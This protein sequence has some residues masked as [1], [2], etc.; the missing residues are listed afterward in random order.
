MRA[1]VFG[2]IMLGALTVGIETFTP[3]ASWSSVRVRD[4]EVYFTVRAPGAHSVFL[5]GDFNNWNPTVEPMANDGGRFEV[6]LFL[7]E[8]S[9][10]Y[11]YVVDGRRIDDPD[12]PPSQ[13]GGGSPLRLIE[14]GGSVM[15]AETVRPPQTAARTLFPRIRYIALAES[16]FDS[17]DNQVD[18]GVR[19]RREHLGGDVVMRTDNSTWSPDQDRFFVDRARIT[20]RSGALSFH[21]A[22]NDSTWTS[23]GPDPLVG[24]E[25]VFGYN[26]GFDRDGVA[27]DFSA[28]TGFALRA[29]FDNRRGTLVTPRVPTPASDSTFYV[30]PRSLA[31]ADRIAGETRIEVGSVAVGWEM[32]HE[33]GARPGVLGAATLDSTGTTVQA[34]DTAEHRTASQVWFRLDR[35][36]VVG[37]MTVA[38]G[39]A[40]GS[41]HALNRRWGG[42]MA[43]AMAPGVAPTVA[44]GQIRRFEKSHRLMI[45]MGRREPLRIGASDRANDRYLNAWAE[46][47]RTRFEFDEVPGIAVHSDAR[48]HMVTAGV[49]WREPGRCARAQWRYVDQ[50]YG[51]A[52]DELYRGVPARD[53]W[54]GA[55][56]EL[57]VADLAAF[58]ARAYAVGRFDALV[59]LHARALPD[60]VRVT[61]G[62]V[63]ASGRDA[64][65]WIDG[66][67]RRR[68][69][70]ST[71][72]L[73]SGRVA[74]YDRGSGGGARTFRGAYM[75]I[76]WSRT[77]IDWSVGVGF[78]PESF[79]PVT[80]AYDATAR[81]RA[82][83]GALASGA[84][85]AHARAL[86]DAL[87][88]M[89][90]RI[91]GINGVKV[92]C[93]LH[94]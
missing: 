70:W 83:R 19:F 17:T 65:A 25:G 53:L 49:Q 26:A 88:E 39:R 6:S 5:V 94:F 71:T 40:T 47:T 23:S 74:R 67:A 46:W 56:D 14:R 42:T 63:R 12:N 68:L 60:T 16:R 20:A 35:V 44:P 66:S 31:G 38:W 43:A 92:E 76:A 69:P 4:E 72:L 22:H 81:A 41:V 10:R 1:F 75:E 87:I 61:A 90:D 24:H 30:A 7:V 59:Q 73:L 86:T 54:T 55:R 57:S 50:D 82:L 33:W 32:R 80:N 21:G 89:E 18:L 9:Y 2:V 58:G 3:G 84:T 48:V 15:L 93:V 91:D 79:N 37:R 52:P 34:Y 13:P 85:R 36:A 27:I 64:L 11:G 29:L 28:G 62:G 51:A 78:D 8:G 77:W 45:G